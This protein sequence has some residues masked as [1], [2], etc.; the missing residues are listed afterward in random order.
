MHWIDPA[1]LPETS[2]VLDCFLLNP[3]GE[4]DGF[5]LADGT[6]VHV[7]PHMGAEVHAA[8]RPGRTI[9]VRGVRPR[10]AEMIAAV[11]VQADGGRLIVDDGPPEHTEAPA[12]AH[13]KA[14]EVRSH[15]EIEGVVRRPLHGPKGELRGLLLEDGRSGRFPPHHAPAVASL[16]Q[17]GAAVVIRGEALVT[18]YGTVLDMHEVGPSRDEMR[19]IHGKHDK[20]GKPHKPKSKPKPRKHDGA[21]AATA[22]GARPA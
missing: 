6:E 20:S 12:E 10:D 7:P 2:G 15:A 22:D 9:W 1:C 4:I 19:H 16:L 11:S 5:M 8:L 17:S 18:P 3:H 21:D 13:R 14:R